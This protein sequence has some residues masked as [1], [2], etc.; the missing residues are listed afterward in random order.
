MQGWDQNISQMVTHIEKKKKKKKLEMAP[1]E[2]RAG[3]V[4]THLFV[5]SSPG[6][7]GLI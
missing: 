4:T 3:N 2:R 1:S 5:R 7:S 6:L